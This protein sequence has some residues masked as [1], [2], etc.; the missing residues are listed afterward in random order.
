MVQSYKI[1]G[2]SVEPHVLALGTICAV[3]GGIVSSRMLK[4]N[5][6]ASIKPIVQEKSD[7]GD[8]EKLIAEFIE[9]EV[10]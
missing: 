5:N 8:F 2:K 4:T 9:D 6:Q 3:I 7:S 10:K 1:F